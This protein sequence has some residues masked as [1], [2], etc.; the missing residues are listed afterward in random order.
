MNPQNPTSHSPRKPPRSIPNETHHTPR[1]QARGGRSPRSARIR[2]AGSSAAGA[3]DLDVQLWNIADGERQTLKGHKSWVRSIDFTPDGRRMLTACW[4]GEIRIWDTSHAEAKLLRTDR[5]PSRLGPVCSRQSGRQ[6]VRHLRKRSLR[7]GLEP[8]GRAN[9]CTNSRGTIGMSTG[10]IFIP[11]ASICRLARLD[12][13][14]H[15]WDLKSGRRTRSIDAS[16]MTGY[17]NKFAADMGGARDLRIPPER[18]PMGERG[19]HQGRQLLRR[20]PGSDRRR[21]RLGNGQNSPASEIRGRQPQRHR[22]GRA[23]SSGRFPHRAIADR[24][25]KGELW[26][27]KPEEETPFHVVKL[28]SAARG[29]DLLPDK[30]QLAV[31]HADGF[32]RLYRMTAKEPEPQSTAKKENAG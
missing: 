17:D 23:V 4:G 32:V 21:L 31:A 9:C 1:I 25:G 3:E 11:E 16:V 22:L 27:S 7:E 19:H 5:G 10:W 14:I 30:T 12:G 8:G 29:L 18:Q 24:S 20:D 28:K 26:F 15:I 13:H 2:P 6:Q